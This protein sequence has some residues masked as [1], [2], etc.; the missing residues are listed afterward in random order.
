MDPRQAGY[1]VYCMSFCL[2]LLI[3][4]LP[5]DF[6]SFFLSCLLFCSFDFLLLFPPFLTSSKLLT[7][8]GASNVKRVYFF[9][10]VF[11][12]LSQAKHFLVLA[13]PWLYR[14]SVSFNILLFLTL[15]MFTFLFLELFYILLH[16]LLFSSAYS[17]L[18]DFCVF[19][20]LV[21][22][23]FLPHLLFSYSPSL[24]P[25]NSSRFLGHDL[26]LPYFSLNFRLL[27]LT[28]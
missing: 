7:L 26:C 20:V 15:L 18:P 10:L 14:L 11:L 9:L 21:N 8:S 12:L 1:N 5:I 13:L 27:F 24:P 19:A 17:P 22:Y 28:T 25:F 23:N 6:F 2:P 3:S 4:L 16:F